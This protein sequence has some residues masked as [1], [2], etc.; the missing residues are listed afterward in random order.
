M[1][2]TN[3]PKGNY[4]KCPTTDKEHDWILVDPEPRDDDFSDRPYW[5]C[6]T[7]NL[8]VVKA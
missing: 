1:L 4:G 2:E 3:R 5:Q 8:R 7:C 6:F